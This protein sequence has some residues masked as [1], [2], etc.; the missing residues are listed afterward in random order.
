MNIHSNKWIFQDSVT[1]PANGEV[2][3]SGRADTVTLFIT[4]TSATRTIYFEGSDNEGNWYSIPAFK[5][6]TLT[7]AS[8]TTGNNEAWEIDLTDS[9]YVR[10]RVS[11][12]AGGTVR[13][14]GRVVNSNG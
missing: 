9:V 11:A 5:L 13:I 2:L 3:E 7:M 6:P 4:G 1:A 12:V 10:A 8:S 14:T